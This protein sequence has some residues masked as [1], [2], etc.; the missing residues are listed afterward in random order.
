[1]CQSAYPFQSVP[2]DTLHSPPNSPLEPVVLGEKKSTSKKSN[3]RD[4]EF[5]LACIGRENMAS[6]FGAKFG[7]SHQIGGKE[8]YPSLDETDW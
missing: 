2:L 3:K 4:V 5:Q 8:P 6:S 1:M 7:N